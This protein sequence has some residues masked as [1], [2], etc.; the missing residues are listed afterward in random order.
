VALLSMVLVA[1]FA[2]RFGHGPLELILRRVTY[3]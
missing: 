3:A 2:R 1:A